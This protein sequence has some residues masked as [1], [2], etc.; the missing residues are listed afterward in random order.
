VRLAE[1]EELEVEVE[2]LVAGGEGLARFEGIPVFVPRSAPGDRL[3]VRLTERRPDY[4]RAEIVEI[5]SPGPGRREPP[6]PYFEHCGGC[7]LQHLEDDLQPRL[8]A[9]AVVETLVRIGKMEVPPDLEVIRG[10]PWGYR[11]RT[12]LQ[13]GAGPGGGP[14][15]GYHRRRSHDLVAVDRCPVLVPELEALL[16]RLPAVLDASAEAGGRLPRRLD[17]AAGSPPPGASAGDVT[18]APVVEGLPHREVTL[19]VGGVTYAYDAR[20]F[21]QAHRQLAARLVERVV[22]EAEGETACDLYA[23]VGLFA[24]PLAR[25]YRRVVAVE[26]DRVAARFC[27]NNARRNRLAQVEVVPKALESWI[28]EL[29]EDL[30]RAI[31]DPPRSGLHRQVREALFQRGPRHLTY[32]SCHPATLAR[33][34]RSL[35]HP[36]RATSLVLID[37]FPQTG[38]MEAVVQLERVV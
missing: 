15:V 29:P 7:D 10:A 17:L 37:L 4:G 16:P 14:A 19:E 12:Q 3:R 35:L 30:D 24:L 34:L 33:D 2:K 11:L 6:C 5:L 28:G 22:G 31:V 9:E 8:K 1:L 36:Y 38:H 13:V 25:R 20:A 23:G 27:R 18:A 32:V 26:G 21:F